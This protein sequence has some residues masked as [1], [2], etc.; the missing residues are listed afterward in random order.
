M[1]ERSPTQAFPRRDEA[2]RVISLG[3][4]LVAAAGGTLVGLAALALVDGVLALI[5]LGDFGRASGWL[6]AILPAFLFFDDFR[7]WRGSWVRLLVALGALAVGLAAGLLGA[8]L[9]QALPPI[10]SG[11]TGALVAVLGYA[12]IWY[13]GIRWLTGHRGSLESS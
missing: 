7:A 13:T 2:G 4:L 6:A 11:A 1:A 12:V 8:G 10:I 3:E 5:G 9:V